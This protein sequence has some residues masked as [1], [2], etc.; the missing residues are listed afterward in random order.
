MVRKKAIVKYERLEETIEKAGNAFFF[1]FVFLGPHP[2]HKEFPRLGVESEPQL[3]A[4]ITATA[5]WHPSRVCNL[6]HSSGQRGILNPL[7]KA[8]IE[9][10]SSWLLVRFISAEPRRELLGEVIITPSLRQ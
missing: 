1:L 2:Q 4:Y 7:S 9:P 5:T 6:Y 10:A 3:P 8:G